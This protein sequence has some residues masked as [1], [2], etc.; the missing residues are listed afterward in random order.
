MKRPLPEESDPDRALLRRARHAI[1]LQ[2]A[3]AITASLMVLGVLVLLVVTRSQNAAAGALLRQTVA[4]ADDVTDPPVGCRPRR[5]HPPACPTGA[6]SIGCE[7]AHAARR[8][9]SA[10]AKA[11]TWP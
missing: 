9:G 10:A 11:A 4:S 5:E 8:L 7:P 3:A 6:R 1:A 2:T